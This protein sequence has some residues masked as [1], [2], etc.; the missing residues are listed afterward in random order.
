MSDDICSEA[1]LFAYDFPSHVFTTCQ[2][3]TG[4]KNRYYFSV[5]LLLFFTL[6]WWKLKLDPCFGYIPQ[7]RGVQEGDDSSMATFDF[8]PMLIADRATENPCKIYIW[9]KKYIL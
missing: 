3:K 6:K 9:K 7:G 5:C 1:T 8:T 4:E 2:W